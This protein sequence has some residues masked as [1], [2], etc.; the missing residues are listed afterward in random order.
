MNKQSFNCF[1][2]GGKSHDKFPIGPAKLIWDLYYFGHA[3]TGVGPYRKLTDYMDDLKCA[4]QKTNFSRAKAVMKKMEEMVENLIPAEVENT[5]LRISSMTSSASDDLFNEIYSQ[6]IST[7]YGDKPP[8]RPGE[9]SVNTLAE[10][11]YKIKRSKTQ[12]GV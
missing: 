11:L 10:R 7:L 4:K 1:T 9:I 8:K 6:L 2:G 5:A 12:Q 3:G